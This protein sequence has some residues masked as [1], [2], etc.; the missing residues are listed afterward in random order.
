MK[1]LVERFIEEDNSLKDK[2]ATNMAGLKP[3]HPTLNKLIYIEWKNG[4]I[5][6][7]EAATEVEQE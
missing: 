3:R 5:K 1:K 6:D 4:I 7:I 2:V